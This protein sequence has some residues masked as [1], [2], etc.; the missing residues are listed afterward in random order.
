MRQRATKSRP[1]AVMIDLDWPLRHHH[2]VFA[3]IRR[4]ADSHP[5][6]RIV[7]DP[8]AG[9]TLMAARSSP[10]YAGVIARPTAALG[11]ASEKTGVPVVSVLIGSVVKSFP[12]VVPDVEAAGRIVARHMIER[13]YE[14]FGFVGFKR[15]LASRLLLAGFAA[16]LAAAGHGC[17]EFYVGGRNYNMEPKA[18]AKFVADA[19][20]WIDSWSPPMGLFASID[21][22]GRYLVTLLER[23]GLSVPNDVALV[24]TGNEPMYCESSDPSISS[25]DMDYARVG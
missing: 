16:E 7:L 13:G 24:G 22:L 2:S 14:S 1:V 6:F 3:G 19:S 11:Q 10:P 18:W 9:Q 4:Y 8:F 15:E 21:L 12:R 20:R 25:V 5:R 17:S 23:K